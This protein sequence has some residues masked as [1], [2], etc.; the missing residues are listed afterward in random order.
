MNSLSYYQDKINQSLKTLKFSKEPLELY[1]PIDYILSVGGKR[2]RPSLLLV[3]YHMFKKDVNYAIN[4]ALAIE[5][6]HNF[7]LVHD[8]IMDRAAL[9]R[10][11]PTVHK[12]W[13]DS[14]A[15]LSGD[16]MMIKS[17]ELLFTYPPEIIQKIIH[18]FNHTALQVCEGQQ[19]DMNFQETTGVHTDD[20]LMMIELKTAVLIAAA[21]KIGAL[22]AGAGMDQAEHL[23]AF[24]KNIGTAFQL[25]DD[26]LDVYA[27]QAKFGKRTGGDI[28]ENKKTFL[29][30]N[31]YEKA[32][33]KDLKILNYWTSKPDVDENE[34]IR[35]IIELFDK[36][37]IKETT[38][39]KIR[40]FFDKAI[41]QLNGI[42]LPNE[43]KAPLYEFSEMLFNRVK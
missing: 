1:E 42:N 30:V 18:D 31:V 25:Q 12:K 5:V 38:E 17:Y 9:R 14:V 34:K 43:K 7:T 20:Y 28:V 21:L 39:A 36:Y 29:L 22:I 3:G 13:D 11:M 33:N 6:F 27:D 2:I 32:S 35:A 24:G 8:D 26:L 15:I 19:Y 37:N 23:Y 16:A 40:Y 10:S 4:A 41:E